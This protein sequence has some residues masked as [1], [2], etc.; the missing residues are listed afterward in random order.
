ME[1]HFDEELKKLSQEL[2]RMGGLVEEQI[3]RS[4][5]SLVDRDTALAE[6]VLRSDDAINMLEIEIEEICLKFLALH[7][8]AGSD[9][10]FITMVMKI[11]NDLERMGDQA[12]NIAEHTLDLLKQPLLK[13]LIDIP[14]MASLA[15]KMVKDSLDAFVNRNTQLA[16]SVC[17][18]D[19]EVDNLN[20][21][22]FRELLT[23]M[24]EDSSKI[25]RSVDLILIGRNI[26]RVADHATNIGEDVIYLVEGK[27]IKHHLEERRQKGK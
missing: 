14:R 25:T 7:Q 10:R 5:K 24:M 22:I 12:V 19:D 8:P 27:T 2:L 13:P 3:S 17:Q 15:Q 6:N 18:R 23:Y 9:L 11:V 4:V 26:E 21:Q 1:R 16:R 20:D